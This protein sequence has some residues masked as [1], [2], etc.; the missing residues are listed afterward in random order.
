MQVRIGGEGGEFVLIE[1]APVAGTPAG[2]PR[3]TRIELHVGGF[4]TSVFYVL[5]SESLQ[6]FRDQLASL[7]RD[8]EGRAVLTNELEWFTIELTGDGRGHIEATGRLFD[9]PYGIYEDSNS[10][11][12]RMGL[13]QTFLPAILKDLD[14][15][16]ASFRA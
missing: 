14:G 9:R 1:A 11:R 10:F 15:L 6:R 5:D 16:I 13:D 3:R 12:F 2:H 4:Q 8:L 7:Y